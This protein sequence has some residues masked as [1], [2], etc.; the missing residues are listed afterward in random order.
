MSVIL[1]IAIANF[2]V[3]V[4][5]VLLGVY[6]Y[7]CN[8][9]IGAGLSGTT[10]KSSIDEA[11]EIVLEITNESMRAYHVRTIELGNKKAIKKPCLYDCSPRLVFEPENGGYMRAGE[12]VKF[13]CSNISEVDALT[14]GEKFG[15]VAVLT[16]GQR[17]SIHTSHSY[18]LDNGKPVRVNFSDKVQCMIIDLLQQRKHAKQN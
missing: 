13:A 11:D 10:V 18:M 6:T 15:I 12:M 14:R 1:A 2:V 16:N 8:F 9:L 17:V 4:F 7:R 5:G 3:Q